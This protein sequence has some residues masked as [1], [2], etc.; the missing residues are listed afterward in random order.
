MSSGQDQTPALGAIIWLAVRPM[1]RLVASVSFGY[2]LSKKDLLSAGAARGLGQIILNVTLPCLMLAK[3]VPA[4]NSQ[5]VAALGPLVLVA[6]LYQVIG[7]VFAYV[8][9]IVF[10]VPPRFQRGILVAGAWSNWGDV[11]V[12]VLTSITSQAP[13]N[14]STDSTLAVA[15]IAPFLLVYT[16]T[17]FP[18]G[19]YRLL[20]R[21]FKNQDPMVEE[22]G[23]PGIRA[24]LRN[25]IDLFRNKLADV[26]SIAGR[27]GSSTRQN[28]AECEKIGEAKSTTEDT[29][30]EQV[31]EVHNRR[32]VTF[33]P[34]ESTVAPTNVEPFSP[35][36]TTLNGLE[37]GLRVRPVSPLTST[38]PIRRM[39]AF[40]LSLIEPITVTIL[41]AI[42]ISLVPTLKALFVPGVAGESIPPAPDGQPP[43]A[44]VLDIATFFGNASVPLGLLC[45]GSA[46]ARMN[47][48]RP[49]RNAP[50]AS[51]VAL[52]L[53]KM[54]LLPVL[55]VLIVQCLTYHTSLMDPNDKVLRFV[56]IFIS[57]VPTAT[58]Q[59]YLTSVHSPSGECQDL[60]GYLIAQYVVYLFTV[61]ILSAFALHILF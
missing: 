1:I 9:R 56:A 49:L 12:A 8:I 61:V 59:V 47:I 32:H 3:L 57:G 37:E 17:L 41:A 35:N 14:P 19:G 22:G 45:L 6:L 44:F 13:F 20:L 60:P 25:H 28:S 40:L 46:F 23:D 43:L 54:I 58:T 36:G 24:R 55:A 33:L 16:I 34:D 31:A 4:F 53:A 10:Y 27:F 48:P 38:G 50:L 51:M 39:R 26:C 5:N 29:S 2:L 52:A 18:L 11:P 15:Y 7:F 42:L 21:D 30:A